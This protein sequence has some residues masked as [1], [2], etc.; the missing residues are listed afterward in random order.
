MTEQYSGLRP[1]KMDGR[2]IHVTWGRAI[3]FLLCLLFRSDRSELCS[4]NTGRS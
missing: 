2:C 1:P 3:A 4:F